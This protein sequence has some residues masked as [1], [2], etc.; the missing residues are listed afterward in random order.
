MNKEDTKAAIAVMQAYV[1]GEEIEYRLKNGGWRLACGC[2]WAW[3]VASYRVK[4]TP[5]EIWLN[6]Y[7]EKC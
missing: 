7:S 1:D 6:E 4:H 2:A 5:R 3:D